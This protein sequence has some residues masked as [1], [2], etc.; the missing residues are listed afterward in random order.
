MKPILIALAL[1]LCSSAANAVEI[2]GVPVYLTIDAGLGAATTTVTANASKPFM[3]I[4]SLGATAAYSLRDKWLFGIATAL[5]YFPQFTDPAST[6][7][8]NYRGSRWNYVS[9]M[10]GAKLG[11]FT[12]LG[13]FEFLGAYKLYKS[14]A[15]G[16]DVSY[17]SPLGA[18]I[19]GLYRL[20]LTIL[21]SNNLLAG[22]GL[23]W[24]SFS[25]L[26]DSKGGELTLG[27]R[28]KVYSASA[29]ISY[30]F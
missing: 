1:L 21:G 10:I 15:S 27:S 7:T 2:K 8:I 22:I 20:P 30:P 6:G 18:K 12:V 25:K 14:A 16:A 23:E 5:T 24:V 9:P 28:Q 13:E 29:T 26:S 3:G 4:Y 11:D 19:R 17:K